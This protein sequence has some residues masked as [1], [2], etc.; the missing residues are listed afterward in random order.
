M[1]KQKGQTL[2]E[3]LLAFSASILILSAIIIGITTSLSNTQ[4][5]KNQNLANS[6]AQEGMAVVRKIKDSG[7]PA[8]FQYQSGVIYCIGPNSTDLIPA[9]PSTLCNN[10]LVGEIFVRE[11]ILTHS[12]ADCSGGT[13]TTIKVSWSDN[14]CSVG[15]PFC[16][17]T[18]LITCFSNI[19]QKIEP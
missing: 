18:E 5:T 3:V 15:V 14:K 17:K 9:S 19:D 16:H 13:K 12:S 2:I 8:F 6:Y 4:N 1:I 10:F 11:V 7:W